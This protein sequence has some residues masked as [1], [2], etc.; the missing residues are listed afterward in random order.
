MLPATIKMGVAQVI[1]LPRIV[2]VLFPNNNT[3]YSYYSDIEGLEVGDFAIVASPH[4]N[5]YAAGRFR[6][7]ELDG[8]PTVV[9]V[10]STQETVKAVNKAAKWIVQKIDIAAYVERL[11]AERQ[12]EVLRAKIEKA[13]KAALEQAQLATLR[14]L[15]PE[16]DA[17]VTELAKLTG[18]PIEEKPIAVRA[19]K[20]VRTPRAAAGKTASKQRA[21]QPAAK[22]RK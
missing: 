13:K 14:T 3:E 4:G 12:L 16:L 15:S 18:V 19:H 17:L 5:E 8:Y 6:S 7:T 2:S 22:R 20:R 9:R 1:S 21:K 10:V 11:N